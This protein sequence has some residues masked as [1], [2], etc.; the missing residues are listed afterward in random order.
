MNQLAAIIARFSRCFC[1]GGACCINGESS[2]LCW[3][4]PVASSPDSLSK[5]APNPRS[6]DGSL[7]NTRVVSVPLCRVL[8]NLVYSVFASSTL[9]SGDLFTMSMSSIARSLWSRKFPRLFVNSGHA[10][11]LPIFFFV[12]CITDGQSR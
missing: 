3:S 11:M 2:A 12:F 4:P 5:R 9:Q 7:V 8:Y 1:G 6:I 10:K